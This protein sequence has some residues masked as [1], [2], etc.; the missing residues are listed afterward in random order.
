MCHSNLS[1]SLGSITFPLLDLTRI[2]LLHFVASLV[3]VV[4]TD[5]S[6]NWGWWFISTAIT[7]INIGKLHSLFL[8]QAKRNPG[9]MSLTEVELLGWCCGVH[10]EG[11]LVQLFE[12]SRID[13]CDRWALM[14]SPLWHSCNW[15]ITD[16]LKTYLGQLCHDLAA[17][18]A[19]QT[20]KSCLVD[21]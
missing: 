10:L 15:L 13:S 18:R 5:N 7:E 16:R 12:I 9:I 20:K 8:H 2:S 21:P 14:E 19:Y 17:N 11:H 1:Q 6:I 3:T 4:A